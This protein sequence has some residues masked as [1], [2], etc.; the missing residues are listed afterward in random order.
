MA[1][2]G[3]L[4]TTLTYNSQSITKIMEVDWP[5]VEKVLADVTAHDSSSGWEEFIATG[6]FVAADFTVTVLW[7]K[8]LAGHAALLTAYTA[9]TSHAF[10]LVAPGSAITVAGTAFVSNVEEQAEMEDGYKAVITFAPTGNVT[11]T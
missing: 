2:Q 10:S 9:K 11:I 5:E 1:T 6:K 4:G 3:G 8:A 7:D